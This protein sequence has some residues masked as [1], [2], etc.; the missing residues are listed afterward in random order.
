[1]IGNQTMDYYVWPWHLYSHSRKCTHSG[2]CRRPSRLVASL[3]WYLLDRA[4]VH[5]ISALMTW[6]SICQ[7]FPAIMDILIH[8]I[9]SSIMEI[10]VLCISSS[11]RFWSIYIVRGDEH[12][13]DILYNAYSWPLYSYVSG[14]A[15]STCSYV[16]SLIIVLYYWMSSSSTW[17]FITPL[18][19]WI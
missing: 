10:M 18:L 13:C 4:S 8:Y 5:E 14:T 1:M 3:I 19:G 16:Q 12:L 7:V 15:I 9:S 17:F 2:L 6:S 11:W